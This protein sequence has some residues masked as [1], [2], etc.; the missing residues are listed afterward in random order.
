M[1]GIGS[2]VGG[3][4]STVG[5]QI[6]AN[7]LQ[8]KAKPV[9]EG[10]VDKLEGFGKASFDA[11]KRFASNRINNTK[12][13]MNEIGDFKQ[14]MQ[15]YEGHLV[16]SH[17]VSAGKEMVEMRDWLAKFIEDNKNVATTLIGNIYQEMID[18]RRLLHERFDDSEPT[19]YKPRKMSGKHLQELDKARGVAE[20]MRTHLSDSHM[21]M[22]FKIMLA[23]KMHERLV[24]RIAEQPVKKAA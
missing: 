9:V 4:V 8:D 24:D 14:S 6:I 2:F 20:E 16:E 19:V 21:P 23:S 10:L 7:H 22:H 17:P 15:Q 13:L 18:F 11:G 12:A 5:R 1:P 3:I